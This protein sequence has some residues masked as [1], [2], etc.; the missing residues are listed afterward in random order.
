MN[1]LKYYIL[2]FI[3][4]DGIFL[5]LLV[6]IWMLL[7]GPQTHSHILWY[8]WPI[9][10]L[11]KIQFGLISHTSENTYLWNFGVIIR[12]LYFTLSPPGGRGDFVSQGE[13]CK[14]PCFTKKGEIACYNKKL[15]KIY[16][17]N[18]YKVKKKLNKHE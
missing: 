1:H 5:I 14:L 7:W 18:Q 17:K 8:I 15:G 12:D 16:I 11:S 10:F 13:V 4:M 2:W 6:Q 3:V 9:N